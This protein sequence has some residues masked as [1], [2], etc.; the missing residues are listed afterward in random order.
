MCENEADIFISCKKID[1]EAHIEIGVLEA[2]KETE[3]ITIKGDKRKVKKSVTF[4]AEEVNLRVDINF[5]DVDV[6]DVN[7]Y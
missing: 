1:S 3:E 5:E 4:E 7:L 2:I 6:L